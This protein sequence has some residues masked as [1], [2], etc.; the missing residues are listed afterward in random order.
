[1]NASDIDDEKVV[2]KD[3]EDIPKELSGPGFG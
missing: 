2:P 1:V 3:E